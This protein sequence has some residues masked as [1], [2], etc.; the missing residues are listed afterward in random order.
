MTINKRIRVT[1]YR[2]LAIGIAAGSLLAAN[3]ALAV[4]SLK[5]LA[6]AAPGGGWDQTARSLQAAMQRDGIVKQVTV[7]NKTGAG[8]T[9]GLAH[10]V[11]TSKGDPNALL[12]GGMIM[13]GAIHINKSP[14]NL[15][16]VTPLARLT[17][18]YDVVV[19][20]ADSKIKS[21]NDLVAQLKANPGS[22][23]WG[24]GSAGGIDHIL[25][26]MIARAVGAD[27]SKINYIAHSGG[28]EAQATVVGGH[29]TAGVNGYA[30]FAGQIKAGKLRALAISS[31]KRLPGV[32]IPTLKEQGIDVAIANW[33]GIFAAPGITDA[34]KKAL[35]AVVEKTVKSGTW[36]ETLKQR[37]WTD[38]Y[39]A[40][41]D[42][43]KFLDPEQVR[44]QKII[45]DLGLVK[46][47]K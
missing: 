22:V 4:D 9:V 7:E 45:D 41:D 1:S 30:E 3:P 34:Q 25:A 19:V 43:K 10:F 20:T 44:I 32:D 38:L 47:K 18:E 26:A 27:P 13:V 36:R 8:G 6:P 33:R 37:D 14:V 46:E 28:G 17:G 2:W 16:Q 40:A 23:S 42:F 39:L 5:L 31:E 11:N 15:S 21:M 35:A 29:V 12:V 24:G